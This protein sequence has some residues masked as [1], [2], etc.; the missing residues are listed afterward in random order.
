MG[1]KP[2][3]L[4][5]KV[6]LLSFRHAARSFPLGGGRIFPSRRFFL[7]RLLFIAPFS[8]RPTFCFLPQSPFFPGAARL[9]A[10]FKSCFKLFIDNDSHLRYTSIQLELSKRRCLAKGSV[11]SGPHPLTRMVFLLPSVS[12]SWGF[13]DFGGKLSLDRQ[14]FSLR[15]LGRPFGTS[16]KK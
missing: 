14:F 9:S 6:C 13:L 12:A 1:A 8:R 16:M 10:E 5:P 15:R 2:A 11:G 4:S 3:R 7:S